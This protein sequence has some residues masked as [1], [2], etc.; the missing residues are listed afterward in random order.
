MFAAS[1]P[2][3]TPRPFWMISS[4]LA[5]RASCF[6][7]LAS[8]RACSIRASRSLYS[9]GAKGL[10]K[11]TYGSLVLTRLLIFGLAM[12]R[13]DERLQVC[14]DEWRRRHPKNLLT[15]WTGD[16]ILQD[17]ADFDWRM[18]EYTASSHLL[19]LSLKIGWCG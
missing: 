12:P 1:S 6:A 5:S 7:S 11:F 18:N 14:R 3:L 9:F 19:C 2:L 4:A 16:A 8:V 13:F 10:R 15:A 17:D